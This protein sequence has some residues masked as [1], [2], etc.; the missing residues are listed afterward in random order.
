MHRAAGSIG[1]RTWSWE[2]VRVLGE[3]GGL[4]TEWR[5]VLPKIEDRLLDSVVYL[6]PNEGAAKDGVKIGGSG[7]LVGVLSREQQFVHLYVVTNRHVV[8][9]DA[10]GRSSRVVR[11]TSR[12]EPTVI[13]S[14]PGSEWVLSEEDDLAVWY[15]GT[16]VWGGDNYA[17]VP[18]DSLVQERARGD[19]FVGAECVML[20]RFITKDGKQRNLPTARFGNIS[21]LPLEPYVDAKGASSHAFLVETRSQAGYSGSPVFVY[22]RTGHV[23]VPIRPFEAYRQGTRM[24]PA[25]LMEMWNFQLLGIDRSHLANVTTVRE[26]FE[27]GRLSNEPHP[28]LPDAGVELGSGMLVVVPAWKLAELINRED[29]RNVRE[30]PIESDLVDEFVVQLDSDGTIGRIETS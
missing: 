3:D 16:Q 10:M 19:Y 12:E 8:E 27:N 2:I 5:R 23:E 24:V 30:G 15:F 22:R 29:V 28:K 20:G 9:D 4:T 1:A 7:F 21:M 6:Y 25:P 26:Q 17:C 14:A 13:R 11:L 18:F